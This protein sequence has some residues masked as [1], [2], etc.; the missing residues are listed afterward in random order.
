M[1]RM[2][3][4]VTKCTN[5]PSRPKMLVLFSFCQRRCYYHHHEFMIQPSVS[6]MP[7]EQQ[8]LLIYL[9]IYLWTI[10]GFMSSAYA[11]HRGFPCCTPFP[12]WKPSSSAV[13][14]GMAAREQW[15]WR[16]SRR[17]LPSSRLA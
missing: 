2:R 3:K 5:H 14:R 1:V 15:T 17:A 16:D 12:W 4:T 6:T 9:T 11:L 8:Y 7:M 13:T 10:L